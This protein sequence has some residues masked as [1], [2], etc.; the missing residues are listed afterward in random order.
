MWRN[1]RKMH[2][3]YEMGVILFVLLL[4]SSF[5]T[6]VSAARTV[7]V[8]YYMFDGF[9]MQDAAG[10]RSGYG[11]D[12]LQEV[13]RY[14]GWNY[15]YVGYDLGWAKLQ[16]MLDAGEIDL[17]T[18]ARKTPERESKYIFSEPMGTSAGILS[19]RSGNERLVT[20]DYSTYD[21]LR[22]GQIKDSSI[23]ENFRQFAARK[24][25]SYEP[26]DFQNADE[27][28]AALQEGNIDAVCTTNL[29][30]GKNEW[31]IDRFD[32]ADFFAMLRPD[33]QDLCAELDEAMRQMDTYSPGWRTTFWNKY[34]RQ[35]LGEQLAF[36]VEEKALLAS[37]K[38]EDRV[39]TVLVNPDRV[40]YSYFVD[41]EAKG[42]IPEI[43]A[44]ISRRTGLVF[45]IIAK[46]NRAA[47]SAALRGKEADICMDSYFDYDQAEQQGYRLTV[48]YLSMPLSQ[49]SR[50]NL[51]HTPRSA[52]LL[53]DTG[54]T[55]LYQKLDPGIEKKYYSSVEDCMEAVIHGEVDAAYV[56]PYTAQH[57]LDEE[58]QVMLT[59]TLMSQY[60]AAFAVGVADGLDPRMVTILNKAVASVAGNYTDQ[61]I[62]EQAI[63]KKTQVSLVG[64]AYQNPALVAL[65]AAILVAMVSAV[66]FSV[67]RQKMVLLIQQKN[68]ALSEAVQKATEANEAKSRFLSGISHDMRTPLNGILGFTDFALQEDDPEKKQ[69]HLRKIQQSGK[70]LRELI[71]DTLDLS[72]IESG[73]FTLM[74]EYIHSRDILE[75]VLVVIQAAAEKRQQY[76][77]QEL[78]CP[79]DEV[80]FADPLKMKE[81][82]L[83]LLSNAVKYTPIGGTIWL[84]VKH[85]EQAAD[86]CSLQIE[87]EDTGIGMSQE[88]MRKLYEP[89]TQERQLELR[90]ASGSGLGLAIVKRIVDLMQGTITVQSVQGKGTKFVVRLPLE[91]RSGGDLSAVPK[92]TLSS[93]ID[94]ENKKI[95]LCEDNELNQ[96]IACTL[97]ESKKAKVICTGNGAEGAACFSQSAIGEFAAILMDIHMPVM[98]GYDAT[99]KIRA[100]VRADARQIPIIAMTADAYAEDVQK[101]LAAGMDA[102][103]AKPIYPEQLFR[104]LQQGIQGRRQALRTK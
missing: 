42:I 83:N 80:V 72:R 94:F 11:Y 82:F 64:L 21:G 97:L 12:F 28:N 5:S 38:A 87:I 69:Q 45:K 14:T 96:E 52:A 62:L 2:R 40:P 3:G 56:Y 77:I 68:Q 51:G 19:V 60:T 92:P 100:F 85:I 67:N 6:A 49:V 70:V 7:R 90:T 4:I 59:A 99:R 30:R 103:I 93:S 24:G 57:Y 46:P 43:C 39:F 71:N 25:F 74:P 75:S 95:L 9:Q 86:D 104:L 65:L 78:S 73:K 26:V 44:E 34:Y 58:Q 101:C 36:S 61:V 17:L 81:V 32:A 54:C 33:R 102:H 66:L 29:R 22:V 84:R 27:M 55:A 37:L 41:G 89:F 20:G 50:K 16:T 48:P 15:E 79:E 47:Y 23:N 98:D 10:H 8:G 18:S 88:F 13:A 63:A 35:D 1:R 76:F 31:I 53:K 91:I